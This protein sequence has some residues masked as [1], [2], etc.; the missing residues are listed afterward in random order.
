[1][2][3]DIDRGAT[4]ALRGVLLGPRLRETREN[5]TLHSHRR[6]PDAQSLE[7]KIQS[8]DICIH[9]ARCLACEER[10]TIT[11]KCGQEGIAEEKQER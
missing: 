10:Q 8:S 7:S 6:D 5:D 9:I 1:M 2:E 11:S 4:E 3:A